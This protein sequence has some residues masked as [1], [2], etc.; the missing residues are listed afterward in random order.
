[1]AVNHPIGASILDKISLFIRLPVFNEVVAVNV[2]IP[3][4]GIHFNP[5]IIVTRSSNEIDVS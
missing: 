1:M 2:N 4:C 3:S 5:M